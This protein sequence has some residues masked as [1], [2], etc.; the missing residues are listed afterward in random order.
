MYV[1]LVFKT[2]IDLA[3]MEKP[4]SYIRRRIRIFYDKNLYLNE[5]NYSLEVN[6]SLVRI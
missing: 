4:N 1:N 3:K 2:K 5:I 6:G